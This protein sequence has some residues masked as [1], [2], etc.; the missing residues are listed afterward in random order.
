MARQIRRRAAKTKGGSAEARRATVSK[1]ARTSKTATLPSVDGAGERL[2]RGMDEIGPQIGVGV[3]A[4]AAVALIEAELVPAVLVGVAAALLP[5]LVP[6]LDIALRPLVHGAVGAGYGMY[7]KAQEFIA[8]AGE[9]LHDMVAEVK[10]QDQ[11][12]RARR[13]AEKA[14]G[15]A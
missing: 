11:T 15:R 7:S 6:G 14:A 13:G 2:V 9:Q 1:R 4:A 3:V 10:A 5:K 8:E 12:R